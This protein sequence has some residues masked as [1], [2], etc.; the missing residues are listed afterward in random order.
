MTFRGGAVGALLC[1]ALTAG[2]AHLPFAPSGGERL[3]QDVRVLAADDMQGRLVGTQGSA[4]ARAYILERLKQEGVRP[5]ASGWTQPFSF[6]TKKEPDR[7]QN[8]VNLVGWVRGGG[9]P[10]QYIVV[11]AH[12]DHLGVRDGQIYNG[13]DDNASGVAG[14]LEVARR[15]KDRRPDHSVIFVAFDGE[16]EGLKGAQAFVA[17]PPVPLARIAFNLNL[18]MISR[19]DRGEIYAVGTWQYPMLRAPLEQLARGA[20]VKLLFG[21]DRPQDT[22]ADHWVELSDQEPFYKAGVPFIFFSVDDHP[23][24][25]KPTDD[26]D[27]IPAPYFREAVRLIGA[28]FRMVDK[29]DLAALKAEPH[30]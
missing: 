29:M 15:L 25:H 1:A 28:T 24:Y 9:H 18:D 17:T 19:L 21:R 8:G 27:R 23:D 13:A 7:V 12:Y 14:M 22:G 5:M 11:S 6:T 10:D 26:P 16:E 4:R 3:M 30:Q 2:C 20:K